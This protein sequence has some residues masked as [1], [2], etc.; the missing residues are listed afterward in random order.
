MSTHLGLPWPDE[1]DPLNCIF[2]GLYMYMPTLN[3]QRQAPTYLPTYV[4][5]PAFSELG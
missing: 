4:G 2:L 1:E 5:D 3:S